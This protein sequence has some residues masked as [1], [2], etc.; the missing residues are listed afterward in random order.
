MTASVADLLDRLHRQAFA[1]SNL[2]TRPS[3]DRWRAQAVVWPKL[4]QATMRALRNVPTG[5]VTD[6]EFVLA[7]TILQPI[8]RN[9]WLPATGTAGTRVP[10]DRRL[11]DMTRVLGGIADLLTTGLHGVADD[12]VAV[13]GLRANLL[14]PLMVAATWTLAT[15]PDVPRNATPRRHLKLVAGI[16]AAFAFI[17]PV[18]RPGPYDDIAAVPRIENSL[19]AAIHNWLNAAKEALGTRKGLSGVTLQTVAADLSV[20]CGAAAATTNAAIVLGQLAE[21]RGRPIVEAITDAN[22]KWREASRWPQTIYLG[23]VRDTGLAD[24]SMHLRQTVVGTLRDANAWADPR[25][26]AKRMR[27]LDLLAVA[28]RAMHA[29]NEAGEL[30]QAAVTHLFW[31]KDR[32]MMAA[33]SLEGAAHMTRA[34]FDARRR[35]TWIPMPRFD[36]SGLGVYRAASNAANATYRARELAVATAKPVAETP[37]LTSSA[38]VDLIQGRI[39]APGTRG[40]MAP[41]HRLTLEPPFGMGPWRTSASPSGLPC[42]DRAE[43]I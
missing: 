19:D 18:L 12:P 43:G 20:I 32:V 15:A 13:L 36:P 10:P 35:G 26:I 9:T 24:A 11:V 17:P 14:S 16:G 21:E 27:G 5:R 3:E 30:E 31:G 23:G 41:A 7:D 22:A 2:P 25:L 28:R 33:R 40:P 8:A 42:L 37:E 6:Q 38:A 29:A 1:I 34:V 4:A 39:A